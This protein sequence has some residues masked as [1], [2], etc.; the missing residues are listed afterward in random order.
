MAGGYAT[1]LWPITRDRPKMV[2]PIGDTTVIDRILTELEA[3][4]RI[5]DVYISTN[6]RFADRFQTHV[7]QQGY[8]KA[9]LSIEGT[10]S[11]AEKLGV[12]GALAELID[13]EQLSRDTLV[14]AGDNLMSVSVET[15]I[16]HFQS[17][18][19]PTLAAYDVGSTDRAGQYGVVSVE[20]GQVT[21]FAEKPDEPESTLI[22]IACYGFPA[23]VLPAFERYLAG[24][25]NPDEP[26]WF[27]QWLVDRASVG[28]FSFDGA[29]FDIGT[30]ESYLDAVNWYLGGEPMVAESA[31]VEDSHL[32]EAVHVMDGAEVVDST[33]ERT[34]V[35]PGASIVGSEIR[36]SIVDTEAVLEDIALSGAQIASYTRVSNS[37]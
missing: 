9:Q 31:T 12:V 4:S 24:D 7:E 6:E 36:N 18:E 20:N 2:L 32:G 17:H 29:W 16:D 14:I 11:E 34:V 19:G 27:I 5:E 26:G 8:E 33:L 30:P 1:R 22:S 10:T 28:A 25:H 35:F 15:F 3:E 37:S 13:R 23:D 21:G